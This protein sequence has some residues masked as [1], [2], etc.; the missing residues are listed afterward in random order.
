[1][2][3]NCTLNT[4]FICC[5]IGNKICENVYLLLVSWDIQNYNQQENLNHNW[6][7]IHNN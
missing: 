2:V 6:I 4:N 1:M 7:P 5:N 3:D